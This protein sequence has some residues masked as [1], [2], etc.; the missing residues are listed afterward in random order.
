MEPSWWSLF[1]E[2]L[3]L[4]KAK[5]SKMPLSDKRRL[6]FELVEIHTINAAA[7]ENDCGASW[8][9]RYMSHFFL[10]K[11]KMTHLEILGLLLENELQQRKKFTRQ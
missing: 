2:E 6:A 8:L 4:Q 7:A 5:E 10:H 3:L 11:Q 9:A 1:H